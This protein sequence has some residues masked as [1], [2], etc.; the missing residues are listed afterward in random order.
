M[1]GENKELSAVGSQRL[2]FTPLPNENQEPQIILFKQQ[3]SGERPGLD[4]CGMDYS[5]C[6]EIAS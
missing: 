4:I 6:S 2:H 1:S 5:S 3:Q